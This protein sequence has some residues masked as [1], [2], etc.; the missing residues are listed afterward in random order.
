MDQRNRPVPMDS[1]NRRAHLINE[2]IR[3]PQIRVIDTDGSQI[4]IMEPRAALRIAQEKELDLVMIADKAEPPVCRIIDYGKFL[5]ELKKQEAQKGSHKTSV[6]ELKMRYTI[7]DHDYQVRVNQAERFLKSG[8][9]VK[10]TIQLRGRENQHS[11]LAENL[12]KKMLTELE[13]FAD[14]QQAPKK[15]GNNVT[16]LLSP[17]T[18]RSKAAGKKQ[19]VEPKTVEA[20]V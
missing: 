12:L 17:K 15:E 4:G 9:R 11:D 5:Y 20:K 2:Y 13:E 6:K 3:V 19:Q 18:A 16:M 7:E 14:I 10:V 8:D 1:K